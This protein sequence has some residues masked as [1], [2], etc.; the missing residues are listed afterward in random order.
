MTTSR[1]AHLSV[2]FWIFA[3][4]IPLAIL[5]L[6]AIIPFQWQAEL[7]ALIPHHWGSNGPDAFG[8]LGDLVWPMVYIGGPLL[9]ALTFLFAWVGKD[10]TTQ[11]LGII[12][13]NFLSALFAVIPLSTAY[14]AR[15]LEDAS[16]LDGHFGYIALGTLAGIALGA[17]FAWLLPHPGSTSTAQI[18]GDSAPRQQLGES[19]TAV[20]I[21]R[22]VSLTTIIIGTIAF[23]ALTISLISTGATGMLV[24]PALIAGLVAGFTVFDI[25]VDRN[26]VSVQSVL[27]FIKRDIPLNEIVE[28]NT[29]Q[30]NGLKQFGGFGF[31][32]GFDGSIGIILRNGEALELKLSQER[33]FVVTM[34]R[35]AEAAGLVN[36]LV[37]RSRT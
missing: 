16:Q 20:W 4:V 30:V 2:R 34:K 13:N 9:I 27:K 18:P 17:V 21:G 12:T 3:A 24:I 14:T 35:S 26:G 6:G 37:E 11:R 31:R 8:S 15:G 28:A 10:I 22:E 19:E 7:P 5:S 36:T 33:R 29:I 32:T 23:V 25:R 1:F